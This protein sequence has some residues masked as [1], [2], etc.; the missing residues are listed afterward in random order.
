MNEIPD[1]A[2]PAAGP[3]PER[4]YTVTREDL[5]LH[6]PP[7]G[8]SL[9]NAHP[10]VYLPIAPGGQARCPY[11]GAVYTLAEDDAC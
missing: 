10:R 5:P 8:A 9:W 1:T 6:C 3:A 2:A 7:D 4:R 11:C